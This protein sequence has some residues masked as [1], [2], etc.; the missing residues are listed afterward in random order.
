MSEQTSNDEL[1]RLCTAAALTYPGVSL[2]A[3]IFRA[4]V[5]AA[6]LLS[7]LPAPQLALRDLYLVSAVLERDAVA[8][9]HLMSLLAR[10]AAV[11]CRRAGDLNAD[12]L[13]QDLAALVLGRNESGA[14][15]LSQYS[16]R[17]SLYSWLRTCAIRVLPAASLLE[18]NEVLDEVALEKFVEDSLGP[19]SSNERAGVIAV[20]KRSLDRA[21]SEMSERSRLVL[22]QKLALG[23]SVDEI[24]SAHGVH[25]ATAARWVEGAKDELRAEL[26]DLLRHEFGDSSSYDSVCAQISD[27]LFSTLGRHLRAEV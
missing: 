21:L 12:E 11:V 10:V 8:S 27:S 26:T 6:A 19:A 15:R 2:P 5:D 1:E 24:G 17:S 13:G 4:R 3:E 20:A 16:G 14:I 18:Q 22:R 23:W 7:S 25:R 9:R